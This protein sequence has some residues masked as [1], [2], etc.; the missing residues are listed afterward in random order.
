MSV[1]VGNPPV[2]HYLINIH[3]VPSLK[4][5]IQRL[6]N[7]QELITRRN[8]IQLRRVDVETYG[9]TGEQSSTINFTKN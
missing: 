6:F 7:A 4:K 2:N 8:A 1:S 9:D 5:V 3:I